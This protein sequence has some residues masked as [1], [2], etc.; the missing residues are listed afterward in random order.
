LS[1][2]VV[3]FITTHE[4]PKPL[5]EIREGFSRNAVILKFPLFTPPQPSKINKTIDGT[6]TQLIILTYDIA[7]AGEKSSKLPR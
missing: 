5:Q 2:E 3:L 7:D 6:E 4:A 1:S